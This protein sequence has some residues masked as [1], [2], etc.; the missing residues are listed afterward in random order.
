MQCRGYQ[1]THIA[2]VNLIYSLKTNKQTSKNNNAVCN[3]TND[4]L[5]SGYISVISIYIFIIIFRRLIAY[6]HIF[7]YYYLPF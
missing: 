1:I 6:K 4:L 3:L 5:L 7:I 2:H